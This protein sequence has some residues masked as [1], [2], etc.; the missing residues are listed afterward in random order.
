[1]GTSD[2]D[3]LTAIRAGS[4]TA[5]GELFSRHADAAWRTAFAIVR[6]HARAEDV[7]QDAFLRAI[8]SEGRFDRS[9]PFRPWLLRIVTNRAVD[10]LRHERFARP[11]YEPDGDV[12]V[13]ARI[14]ADGSPFDVR[15]A[16]GRLDPERRAIVVLRFWLDLSPAEIADR[17]GVPVG[18]VGSRLSRALAELAGYLEVAPH[19]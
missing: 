6:D 11:G 3:L 1:M 2:Q 16:L 5:W 9:R 14:A 12:E 7:V 10:V 19:A 18:T 4:R 13:P 15:G 17:L 8:R